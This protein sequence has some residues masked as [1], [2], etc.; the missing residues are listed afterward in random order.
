MVLIRGLCVGCP[1][2]QRWDPSTHPEPYSLSFD[3]T[4]TDLRLTIDANLLWPPEFYHDPSSLLVRS[5]LSH[6]Y[7]YD[8][9]DS[10]RRTFHEHRTSSGRVLLGQPARAGLVGQSHPR[11]RHA[12]PQEPPTSARQAVV[13]SFSHS[14]SKAYT[15]SVTSLRSDFDSMIHGR[16]L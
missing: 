2:Q 6:R 12:R 4:F 3:C 13:A 15:T 16:A 7:R 5:R 10:T 8:H 9:R 11:A 1:S 14:A